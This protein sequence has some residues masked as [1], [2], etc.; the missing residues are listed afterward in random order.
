EVH[1]SNIHTREAFRH[2]SVV[3]RYATG[4]VAGLGVAGYEAALGYLAAR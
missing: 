3:S 1:I 2:H 4:V